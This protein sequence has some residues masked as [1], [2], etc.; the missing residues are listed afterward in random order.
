MQCAQST[1]RA[2]EVTTAHDEVIRAIEPAR[3][4]WANAKG[5]LTCVFW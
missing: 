1:L 2:D 4:S 3:Q 5:D